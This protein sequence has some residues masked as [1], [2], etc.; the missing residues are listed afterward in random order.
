MIMIYECWVQNIPEGE[1]MWVLVHVMSSDINSPSIT[2]IEA[3][4][5]LMPNEVTS[6]QIHT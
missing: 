3:S 4:L 1:R 5:V 2:L 6:Y